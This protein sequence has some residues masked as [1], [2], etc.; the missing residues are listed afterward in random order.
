MFVQE[1]WV[2]HQEVVEVKNCAKYFRGTN[3]IRLM[4]ISAK[5]QLCPVPNLA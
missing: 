5:V 3:L 4:P 1:N 2:P